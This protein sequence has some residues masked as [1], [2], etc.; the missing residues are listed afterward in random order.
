MGTSA[1]NRTAFDIL[2]GAGGPSDDAIDNFAAAQIT[3]VLIIPW[4]YLSHV[5]GYAMLQGFPR[6]PGLAAMMLAS[7]DER[8]QFDPGQVHFSCFKLGFQFRRF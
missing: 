8:P 4:P 6:A 7:H 2:S 3:M 5:A 1:G